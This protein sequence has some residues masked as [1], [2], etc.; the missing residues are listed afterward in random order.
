MAFVIPICFFDPPQVIDTEVTPIPASSSQPL[1][2][3]ADTGI[4]VGVGVNFNDNTGDFIGMYLGAQGQ[5]V[6]ICI[7][8]NGLSGQ[9][10]AKIPPHSR[11]SLRSMKNEAITQGLLSAVIVSI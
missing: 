11:I 1:Q 5:E 4:N 8:G 2:V 3:I 7:I 9:A 10:W 6:L